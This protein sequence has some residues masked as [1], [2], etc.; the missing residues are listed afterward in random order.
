VLIVVVRAA[1]VRPAPFQRA[2]NERLAVLRWSVIAVIFGI[3]VIWPFA[4]RTQFPMWT[5]V[6]LFACYNLV[7]DLFKRQVPWLAS[8]AHVAMLDL[9]FAAA[10]YF[11][12][13]DP[14][15]PLFVL[16]FVGVITAGVSLPPR[17]SILYTAFTIIVISVIAPTLPEWSVRSKDLPHLGSRLAILALVGWGTTLLVQELFREQRLSDSARLEA[18]R[19][20]ELARVRSEFVHAVSHDLQTPL[21]AARA[22][23]GLFAD[24]AQGRLAPV[25]R[26]L[27]TNVRRNIDRLG[28]LIDDLLAFNGLETG[29]L[30]LDRTSQ[31][32]RSVVLA[33]I[34]SVRL[35]LDEKEQVLEV[36]LPEPMPAL[37]D[38]SRVEQVLVNILTNANRHTP[39]GTRISISGRV[40][41]GE[42]TLIVRDTGPGI[43][44]EQ[45]ARVFDRYYSSS[46]VGGGSGL[47]LA[48]ARSI[49]E[50]HGGRLVVESAPGEGFAV[51][52]AIAIPSSTAERDPIDDAQAVS[53]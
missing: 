52:L 39:K 5:V 7:V 13:S 43:T 45:L 18:A 33:A 24:H 16:F 53:R 30:H 29:T 23:L 8:Y 22:G 40:V 6:L 41:D 47:G 34:A 37:V 17:R 49:V 15:G 21:T 35:L 51:T 26:D 10:A 12:G 42:A 44:A 38:G 31:D 32:L 28:L 36:D 25:E 2:L 20:N 1:R 11:F 48:L 4:G 46:S 3:V 19:L 50:L 14:G 9:L 27:L